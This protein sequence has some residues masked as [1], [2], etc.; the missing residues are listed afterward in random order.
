MYSLGLT[1]YVDFVIFASGLILLQAYNSRKS[2][3]KLRIA[4]KEGSGTM[5]SSDQ[6]YC[7]NSAVVAEKFCKL[8]LN[9]D[10]LGS[11]WQPI[12]FQELVDIGQQNL[13]I[14]R[15]L[16]NEHLR[17]PTNQLLIAARKSTNNS[18]IMKLYLIDKSL[19]ISITSIGSVIHFKITSI[20]VLKYSTTPLANPTEERYQTESERGRPTQ[21]GWSLRED[22]PE[23]F[24]K[25]KLPPPSITLGYNAMSGT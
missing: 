13:E 24:M 11:V 19:R 4:F 12:R 6:Q 10:A 14:F 18:S 2:N 16:S 9:Q 23:L 7:V 22:S 21:Q 1:R 5:R 20:C 15:E 8:M 3:L 17:T 25:S